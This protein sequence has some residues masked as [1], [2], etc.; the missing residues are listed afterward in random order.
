VQHPAVMATI[1]RW[2]AEHGV[3]AVFVLMAIDAL[4]PFAGEL[5]ML[6]AGVIAGGFA[7]AHAA[8][9]GHQIP[10]GLAG[11]VVLSLAGVAG[12]LVGGLIAWTL[13]AKG[14]RA[15]I[16]RHGSGEL[17][18]AELWFARHGDVAVLVGRLTPVVRSFVSFAAGM[19]GG[20]LRRFVAFSLIAAV[21]WC[22][23][24]AAAGWALGSA[25]RGVDRAFG[26]VDVL[27][28][29]AVLALAA[30]WRPGHARRH[31]RPERT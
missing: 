26:Y 18:R 20:R 3:Y 11:Y 30:R 24:F 31:A 12:S 15:L 1:T 22:F 2:I 29:A 8:L 21:I 16:D 4:L 25:W 7:G 10:D 6:Y 13:G 19:Y 28:V 27:A 9:F 23:A 14:G 17:D 5:T